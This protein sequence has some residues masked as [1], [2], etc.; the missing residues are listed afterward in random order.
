MSRFVSLFH[1]RKI[2]VHR[3]GY[4]ALVFAILVIGS[5]FVFAGT[6]SAVTPQTGSVTY[7][8]N[9]TSGGT[10]EGFD[11]GAVLNVSTISGIPVPGMSNLVGHYGTLKLPYG[12]YFF[13][14]SPQ[15]TVASPGTVVTNLTSKFVQV[16]SS[17]QTVSINVSFYYTK[18]V[19]V[20][21]T[22]ITSGNAL[23]KF[24][25]PEG[26]VFQSNV[27]T[28]SFKANLAIGN[29]YATVIY[30][31]KSYLSLVTAAEVST[32]KVLLNA[33]GGVSRYG[34]VFNQSGSPVSNFNLVVVNYTAGYT[35]Q[36]YSFSGGY[37][38]ISSQNGWAGRSVTLT[39]PGFKPLNLTTYFQT[40]GSSS[41]VPPQYMSSGM[42][43]VTYIYSLGNDPSYLNLT[44]YYNITNS[45]TLPFLPNAT[46]G[47][48]YNQLLADHI[49]PAT[50]SSDIQRYLTNLTGQYTNNTILVD[51]S[52]YNLSKKSGL[53]ISSTSSSLNYKATYNYTG[54][55]I[56]VS[57]LE[58]GFN[59]KIDTIGTQYLPGQLLYYYVFE[60]NKSLGALSSPVSQVTS[61][62]SPIN[63]T[64]Q[65]K[66]GFITLTFTKAQKPVIATSDIVA[67][68]G[69]QISNN[70]FLN[71]SQ[72][73]TIIVVPIGTP[74]NFNV[75]KGFYNPTTGTNDYQKAKYKW[76]ENGSLAPGPQTTYN[77]TFTFSSQGIYQLSVNYTSAS[78]ISNNTTFWAFAY[79]GS[80]TPGFY[81]SYGGHYVLKT[82]MSTKTEYNI[83]LP[84]LTDITFSS[85]NS[86]SNI[87]V[88]TH[89]YPGGNTYTSLI[90]K[91]PII[92]T[93]I[94]PGY[95]N[96]ATTVTQNFKTPYIANDAYQYG[97]LNLESVVGVSQSSIKNITFRITVNDTVAPAP[98][99]AIYNSA[100][101]SVANPIAGQVMTFSAN[102]TT[103]QYYTFSQ[104]KF[105]WNIT[106]TNGTVVKPGNST[107]QVISG[108]NTSA[109]IKVKFLTL[110]TLIMSLKATNPSNASAY[111]NK[112]LT[113]V[114]SSPRLVV[115]G[116]YIPKSMEAGS[117][118]TVYV[119][120]SNNGT[121]AAGNFTIV[122]LV[123]GKQIGSEAYSGLAVGQ[124]RNLSF[125]FTP[126]ASGTYS[127]QFE[128]QNGSEPSFFF[129]YGSYTLKASINPPAYRTPLI[130][131]VVIVIIVIIGIAYYRFSSGPSRG[132]KDQVQPTKKQE[133]KKKPEEKKK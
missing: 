31:Q 109:W 22:G 86:T 115:S 98:S 128:A 70:Y 56:N 108:S 24:S 25:T 101:S 62:I 112:T 60:Y 11:T 35:Y 102:G 50:L 84:M 100:G 72:N 117:R 4:I 133:E 54:G 114:V 131:G 7:Y 38:Q 29:I 104:L 17:S 68:W 15:Y 37:F 77:S 106:Y 85:A 132:R 19:T 71:S 43:N 82:N 69:G 63:I 55:S 80:V 121:V 113:M 92:T 74:V 58:N 40:G 10:F 95:K 9:L 26:F 1:K 130:I 118:A 36:V 120:V 6:S 90:Y 67:Y 81:I 88:P 42:S 94:F 46:I 44:V 107:Y 53:L 73:N 57:T 14:I 5:A 21:V 124:S 127:Y 110:T 45:T 75:S 51:G 32:G 89:T 126:P 27:T 87:T 65:A 78:G 3:S 52:N 20:N 48:L 23:V 59:V 111:N 33:T 116:V 103:D 97:Y 96:T 129:S 91:V 49:S 16:S 8:V 93:W 64:P 41:T 30:G 105:F 125:N 39:A 66:T 13:N 79:N 123:N 47:S 122:L 2:T 34:L 83:S 12:S 28:G 119:T 76:Y 99:I 18:Q 61:F